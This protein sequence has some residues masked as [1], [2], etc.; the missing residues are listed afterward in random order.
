MYPSCVLS[1]LAPP[2]WC[3]MIPW[4]KA[5]KL[6]KRK[7]NCCSLKLAASS[8]HIINVSITTTEVT[9]LITQPENMSGI[10]WKLASPSL[11]KAAM[12]SCLRLCYFTSCIANHSL[13]G[14][15]CFLDWWTGKMM[16]IYIYMM[17]MNYSNRMYCKSWSWTHEKDSN[18]HEVAIS[19]Y[20]LHV[21]WVMSI[22]I[23][24]HTLIGPKCHHKNCLDHRQSECLS[25]LLAVMLPPEEK[26]SAALFMYQKHKLNACHNL[27]PTIRTIM[28][29]ESLTRGHNPT[30]QHPGKKKKQSVPPVAGKHL[31]IGL[32]IQ[33]DSRVTQESPPWLFHMVKLTGSIPKP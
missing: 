31:E 12:E 4:V 3:A 7:G 16:Y 19:M 14:N 2:W 29:Q 27:L 8:W 23:L 6:Q 28:I 9:K 32:L 25:K 17:H 21:A 20:A 15:T 10:F 18:K 26:L 11:Q 22:H 24:V 1:T 5:S 33:A 13:A 30:P